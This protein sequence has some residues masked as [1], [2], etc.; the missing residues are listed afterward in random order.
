M[1]DK[2]T[3]LSYLQ[4]HV[5]PKRIEHTFGV[6]ETAR[7]M[8][9]RFGCDKEKAE[10]AALMHDAA[11]YMP[12]DE[13]F[14]LCEQAGITLDTHTKNEPELLH[15][16]AGAALAKICFGVT[17][18]DIINAVLYHTVGRCGMSVLEKIIYLSDI[19]EPTRKP[20]DGI[21]TIRETAKHDLD[22]A[23]VQAM[24]SAM[25][26]VIQKGGQVH[27]NTPLARDA[28]LKNKREFPK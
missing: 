19:I 15:A 22:Q 7:E 14:S 17:D 11:K 18:E 13:A 10:L 1:T 21:E 26:Y 25:A 2:E 20:F 23:V 9:V 27:P 12:E 28:L 8:A 6:A 5:K 16:P 24:D 4:E 3:V